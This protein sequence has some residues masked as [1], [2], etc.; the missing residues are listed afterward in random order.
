MRTCTYAQK[1]CMGQSLLLTPVF[2]GCTITVALGRFSEEFRESF[3]VNT[4]MTTKKGN[5]AEREAKIG[6]KDTI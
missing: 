3:E 5:T 4:Q 6:A 2:G 1:A